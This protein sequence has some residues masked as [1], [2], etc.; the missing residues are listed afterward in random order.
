[1]PLIGRS[2]H[3]VTKGLTVYSNQQEENNPV[4][5]ENGQA[6][7]MGNSWE[8]VL[9][10]LEN[11]WKFAVSLQWSVKSNLRHSASSWPSDWPA[12]IKCF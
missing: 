5:G 7:W 11:M 4:G 10:L 8:R 6:V 9:T 3:E 2:L 12:F 1:M